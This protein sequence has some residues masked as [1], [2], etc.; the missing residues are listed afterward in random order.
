M[1][2]IAL[3]THLECQHQC[4]DDGDEEHAGGDGP[5]GLKHALALLHRAH[6]EY[7]AAGVHSAVHNTPGG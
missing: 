4:E 3:P 6:Q 1:L 7:S 2:H 5:L